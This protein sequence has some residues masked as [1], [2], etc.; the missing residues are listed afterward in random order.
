MELI[1]LVTQIIDSKP[2]ET[3]DIILP[4][5]T[6]NELP[7][8]VKISIT[9]NL[10]NYL[11]FIDVDCHEVMMEEEEGVE[12]YPL[13]LVC[14]FFYEIEIINP[15]INTDEF[16]NTF[17]GIINGL[18]FDRVKGAINDEEQDTTKFFQEIITNP[19]ISF[20]TVDNCTVCIEPT[21]TK[22][23]CDHTL[24]LVCWSKIKSETNEKSCPICREILYFKR[25]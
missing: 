24:C 21:K 14:K 3:E 25:T 8:T 13:K 2:K 6:I 20:A 4:I 19:N 9:P 18:Y 5:E 10:Y 11:F 15:V 12:E 23:L 1:R 22:S 17:K 7:V 16:L